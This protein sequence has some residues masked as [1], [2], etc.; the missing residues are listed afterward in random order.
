MKILKIAGRKKGDG[1]II[2]NFSG[3]F[4]LACIIISFILLFQVLRPFFTILILSAI[5]ATAF[6]PL[7]KR[8]LKLFRNRVKLS[9][10]TITVLLLFLIIVPLLIFI[11]LLGRQAVSTYSFV[12]HQVQGGVLDPYI[13]WQKGGLIYDSL[14]SIQGQSGGLVDFNNIDIKNNISE[15]AQM[16]TSWLAAQSA[17]VLK[18]FGGLLLNFFIFIFALYYFFKDA[19][20]IMKK[21][22]SISPLPQEYELEIFRKFKEISLAALYGIFLTSVVQGIAGGIGFAIVGIPNT[23]FWGTAIAVFSLVPVVGTALI[24]LPAALILFAT[25]QWQAGIFMFFW[26]LLVVST[27]D[28]FLRAFLIGGKTKTNQLLAFLSVFGGIGMFGLVGVIFGPLILTLFFTFLHIYE[29]EYD[30][31]LNPGRSGK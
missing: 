31:V 8:L 27:V 10:I 1:I 5:L 30:K 24:W 11:L 15:T 22:M 29:L 3:Y 26:G 16:V 2:K 17:S 20:A 25:G 21:I 7:Y 28:N 13:K 18:G 9:A 19:D 6:H 12:Q 14:S 4:L 23:L